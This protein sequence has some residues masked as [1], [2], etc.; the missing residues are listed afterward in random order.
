VSRSLVIFTA[1]GLFLLSAT[2]AF[3]QTQS[4]PAKPRSPGE[5]AKAD[6]IAIEKRV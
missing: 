5:I 6:R 2:L 3:S 4:P 1:I